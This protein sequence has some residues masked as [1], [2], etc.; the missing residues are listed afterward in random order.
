VL[1]HIVAGTSLV[2]AATE[3]HLSPKT[4]TAYRARILEKTG[5]SSNAELMRYALERGPFD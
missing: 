5:F 2:D 4:V 1:R 3:M